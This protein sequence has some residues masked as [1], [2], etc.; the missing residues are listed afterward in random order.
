MHRED[1]TAIILCGG[2]GSRLGVPDKTLLPLLGR[3]LVHYTIEALAPQVGRIVLSCGRDPAPYAALGHTVIADVT[4]GDGPLGG[5]ASALP[6]VEGDWILVHPGDSPFPD[7]WLVARLGPTAEAWGVA[8][9]RTGDQR[10]HLV[11]L[12]SRARADEL[13]AYHASGGRAVRK[14]LDEHAVEGVDMS[15]VTDSFFNVNTPADLATAVE[16][17]SSR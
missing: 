17:L 15:D 14:W 10:Q 5:I 11:L 3:P 16:R 12:L 2:A 8:V 4:P 9:P 7:H 13:A 6:A 1:V